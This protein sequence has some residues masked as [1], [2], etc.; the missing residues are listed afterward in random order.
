MSKLAAVPRWRSCNG[1]PRW[2]AHSNGGKHYHYQLPLTKLASCRRVLTGYLG[3]PLRLAQPLAYKARHWEICDVPTMGPYSTVA[4]RRTAS[5]PASICLGYGANHQPSRVW[6]RQPPL[7]HRELPP[8]AL[9]CCE[10][11]CPGCGIE[12][13][14]LMVS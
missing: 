5:R 7:A 6:R 9:L 14:G 10:P 12:I 13:P 8:L 4:D 3:L 1:S 11:R 2:P